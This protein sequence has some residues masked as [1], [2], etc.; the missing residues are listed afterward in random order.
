MLS[1]L[2]YYIRALCNLFMKHNV[3]T[4]L[5]LIVNIHIGNLLYQQTLFNF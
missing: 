3:A 1:T 4:V 5:K 2:S